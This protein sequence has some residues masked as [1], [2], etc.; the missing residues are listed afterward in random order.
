MYTLYMHILNRNYIYGLVSDKIHSDLSDITISISE[1]TTYISILHSDVCK[2][3]TVLTK[4]VIEAFSNTSVS[5][6]DIYYITVTKKR[7]KV[8]TWVDL[9]PDVPHPYDIIGK[10]ALELPLLEWELLFDILEKVKDFFQE[11]LPVKE[12]KKV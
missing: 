7:A 3:A 6:S 8:F 2:L 11:N 12:V 10:I 9:D 4:N 5:K 1:L